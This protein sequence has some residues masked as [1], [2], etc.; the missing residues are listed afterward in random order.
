MFWGEPRFNPYVSLVAGTYVMSRHAMM[1]WL[2]STLGKNRVCPTSF[3]GCPVLSSTGI[4]YGVVTVEIFKFVS[5][6][7]V[8]IS[9]SNIYQCVFQVWYTSGN[10]VYMIDIFI[11]R[12]K[13]IFLKTDRLR[14]HYAIFFMITILT[15]MGR[16]V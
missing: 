4:P 6:L 12:D 15:L 14:R 7:D 10:I 1:D 8:V 11:N 3:P 5:W 13:F 9:I 16:I 2:V